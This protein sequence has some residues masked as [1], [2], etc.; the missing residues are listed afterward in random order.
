MPL[1]H[2]VLLPSP[3]RFSSS[4]TL[5]RR[6]LIGDCQ[7]LSTVCGK[8]RLGP[9]KNVRSQ[10]FSITKSSS[11]SL[12]QSTKT[13]DNRSDNCVTSKPTSG[14]AGRDERSRTSGGGLLLSPA[15]QG[16]E[17]LVWARIGLLD[18]SFP[19]S[20]PFDCRWNVRVEERTPLMN[21]KVLPDECTKA[22][23]VRFAT[24]LWNDI[25]SAG[26][27]SPYMLAYRL[28]D[29]EDANREA[30]LT[31]MPPCRKQLSDG[32]DLSAK[33]L[34]YPTSPK[35]MDQHHHHHPSG[36]RGFNRTFQS[37]GTA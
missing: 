33:Y 21:T 29:I 19:L 31:A 11:I 24:N 10:R 9:T 32:A 13:P 1:S 15:Q 18:S 23:F 17:A 28:R 7:Y 6:C 22:D 25:V 2:D 34:E 27:S 12:T 36:S 35:Y 20:W 8:K 26:T 3:L 30:S 14:G 5:Q 37:K 16:S 4:S